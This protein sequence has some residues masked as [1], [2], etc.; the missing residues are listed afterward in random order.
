MAAE[1]VIDGLRQEIPAGDGVS[2]V[3]LGAGFLGV[4]QVSATAFDYC[5]AEESCWVSLAFGAPP[6]FFIVNVRER[7]G[8]LGLSIGGLQTAQTIANAVLDNLDQ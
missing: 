8:A 4:G 6:H 3:E 5:R 2:Q 1:T 7:I